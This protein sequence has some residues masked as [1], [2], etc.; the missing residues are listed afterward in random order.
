MFR[1]SS[2]LLYRLLKSPLGDL[3]AKSS[4]LQIHLIFKLIFNYFLKQISLPKVKYK[5]QL[6]V[7]RLRNQAIVEMRTT[8][9]EMHKPIDY[10]QL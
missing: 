2:I 4:N 5:R 6:L 7:Q 3:G 10:R 8:T 9:K 1:C